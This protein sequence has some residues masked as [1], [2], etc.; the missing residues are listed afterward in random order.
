MPKYRRKK[1]NPLVTLLSVEEIVKRYDFHPNTIRSWVNEDGLRHYRSVPG[2]KILI[3]EDDLT[4]FLLR[5][6]TG[7][8]ELQSKD[9]KGGKRK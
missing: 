7:F 3:R 1:I 8:S 2:R 4:D 6:Y 5:N 9:E